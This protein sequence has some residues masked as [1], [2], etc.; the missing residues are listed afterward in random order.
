MIGNQIFDE[1]GRF[2][3]NL[4]SQQNCDS[5]INLNL[6][7]LELQSIILEP[8]SIDCNQTEVLLD[9]RNSSGS[10][11]LSFAWRSIEA[12]QILGTDSTLTV[13]ETGTYWLEVSF[14]NNGLT[15]AQSDTV[16]VVEDE[17]LPNADVW[18]H[19]QYRL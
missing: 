5:I 3:I 4:I 17:S 10:L 16:S 8:D 11:P 9:G 7:V 15:C 12:P 14:D 19:E 1:T 2:Q 13:N 18:N 6:D